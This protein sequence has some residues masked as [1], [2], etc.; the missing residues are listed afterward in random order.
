M[1]AFEANRSTNTLPSIIH[2]LKLSNEI[3]LGKHSTYHCRAQAI[4]STT[5]FQHMGPNNK[6]MGPLLGDNLDR[7]KNRFIRPLL[8]SEILS[9]HSSIDQVPTRISIQCNHM[10][11]DTVCESFSLATM[12]TFNIVNYEPTLSLVQNTKLLPPILTVPDWKISFTFL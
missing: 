2:L 1:R 5:V 11:E 12:N 7:S 9:S 8:Q 6:I 3:I 10:A 4:N